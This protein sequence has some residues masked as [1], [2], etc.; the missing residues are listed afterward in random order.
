MAVAKKFKPLSLDWETSGLR[1]DTNPFTS[2]IEGPQGIQIGAAVLDPDTLQPIDTFTMRMKFVGNHRGVS[3]GEFPGITWNEDAERIHGMTLRSLISEPHPR[4]AAT[5]FAEYLARHYSPD[6]R[7]VIVGHNP[8]GDRYHLRQLLW[9]GGYINKFK[10]NHRTIDTHT[11]GYLIYG[12]DNSED[13]FRLVTG[14]SRTTHDAE[15]DALAAASV[16]R[17][18]VQKISQ[19]NIVSLF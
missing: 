12:V 2:Y 1:D 5:A 3:Y 4:T 15:W 11:I 6:D 16:L 7:I 10:I 13:L 14:K 17:Q 18:A 8:E 19:S 9:M